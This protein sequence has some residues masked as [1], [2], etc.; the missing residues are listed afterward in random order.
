VKN[1]L[2]VLQ[3]LLDYAA[4]LGLASHLKVLL[5]NKA[6]VNVNDANNWKPIEFAAQQNA[7]LCVMLLMKKGSQNVMEAIEV[8]GNRDNLE[9]FQFLLR[10]VNLKKLQQRTYQGRRCSSYY[11]DLC[12]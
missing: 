8:A 9:V 3:A 1:A 7:L 10:F 4:L 2:E 5:D 12:K 6:K 11:N